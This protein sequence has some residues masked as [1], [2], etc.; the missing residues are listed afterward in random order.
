MRP[1][2]RAIQPV[3]H[4]PNGYVLKLRKT[5]LESCRYNL[6]IAVNCGFQV[7]PVTTVSVNLLL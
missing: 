7:Q 6:N 2:N 4:S 1:E 5:N 3:A